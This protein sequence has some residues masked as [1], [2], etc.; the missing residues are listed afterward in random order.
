MTIQLEREEEDWVGDFHRRC[1]HWTVGRHRSPA[2]AAVLAFGDCLWRWHAKHPEPK[3]EG[4]CVGCGEPLGE[5]NIDVDDGILV[6]YDT[7]FN[8]LRCYGD[9]WRRRAVIG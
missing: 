4:V 7:E 3:Q 9:I 8:C 2:E 5:H 1:I 6:H